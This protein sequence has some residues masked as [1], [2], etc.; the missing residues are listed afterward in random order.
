M[1]DRAKRWMHNMG[2]QDKRALGFSQ[3]IQKHRG[4]RGR[5]RQGAMVRHTPLLHRTGSTWLQ[6]TSE[7]S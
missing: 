6:E 4:Q 3:Y 2:G 1:A 5:G 7:D